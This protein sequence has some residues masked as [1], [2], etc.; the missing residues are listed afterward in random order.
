MAILGHNI[1]SAVGGSGNLGHD[2]W[3]TVGG[4]GILGH[5]VWYAVAG[6]GS[7]RSRFKVCCW[8]QWQF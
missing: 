5:D 2:I 1:W 3:Y 6:S 4:Y 7:S 8:W